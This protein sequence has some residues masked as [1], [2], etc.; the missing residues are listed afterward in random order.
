MEDSKELLKVIHG[1]FVHS[2]KHIS[3][4]YMLVFMME[5]K[6]NKFLK[7]VKTWW[8]SCLPPTRHLIAEYQS[9]IEKLWEDW[10][11]KKV[12]KKAKVCFCTAIFDYLFLLVFSI[13]FL[14]ALSK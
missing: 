14:D 11:D 4:F 12:C 9:V 5:T 1:Y 7:N 8:I 3:E 6:G 10:I 2:P 13:F